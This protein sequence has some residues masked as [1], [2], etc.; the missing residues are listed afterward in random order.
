MISDKE[1]LEI[2]LDSKKYIIPLNADRRIWSDDYIDYTCIEIL[3]KDNIIITDLLEIDKN[4]YNT[5]FEIEEYN[6]KGIVNTSIGHKKEI[7]LPQGVIYCVSDREDKFFHDCNTESGFSGGALI[8]IKSLTIIGI[9]CGYEK[10]K[11]KNI[12]IYMKE[13]LENIEKKTIKCTINAELNEIKDDLL[14]FC[15]ND[16]NVKEIKDNIN[17]YYNNR[18]V[19]LINDSDKWKMNFDSDTRTKGTN[20]I[21]IK[22]TKLY[23]I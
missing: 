1:D 20:K 10:N 11:K 7:E 9:H 22:F 21:K 4:C 8:L 18:K 14:L 16:V 3:E 15:E 19:K 17:V 13:V 6:K 5:E 12:G 23:Q 2:L